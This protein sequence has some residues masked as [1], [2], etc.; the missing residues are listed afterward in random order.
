M[1]TEL[2]VPV[3]PVVDA[4]EEME[5]VRVRRLRHGWGEARNSQDKI[6]IWVGIALSFGI[7]AI[8]VYLA[9]GL[10]SGC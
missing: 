10:Y 3:K 6:L 8:L 1:K 2:L 9:Y 4:S 7:A 5:E